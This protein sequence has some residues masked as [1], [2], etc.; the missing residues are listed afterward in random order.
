MKSTMSKVMHKIAGLPMVAHVMRAAHGG[1][2]RRCRA[3]RRP[4]RGSGA[5]GG[6]IRCQGTESFVQ[7]ER[8]GT[9]HAAL[10]ARDAIARGYDDI[11]VMFGDTPLIEPALLTTA[12]EKLADGAAVAVLGFRTAEPD[13]LWP[14]DR[15]GRRAAR[16]PRGKGLLR[17]GEE[18]RLLQRRADG[19]RRETGAGAARC[20]AERQRQR[21]ILSDRHRRHRQRTRPQGRRHGGEL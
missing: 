11:L 21:R 17:G 5:G 7:G 16:H 1:G 14:A 2:R 18:D 9:A 12:R 13:R 19:D 3:G 8:L 10:A 15:E 6:F 4:W 20:C